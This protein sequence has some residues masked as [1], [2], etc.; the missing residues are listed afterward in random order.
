MAIYARQFSRG[1]LAQLLEFISSV[2]VARIE[3]PIYLM[4]S[5]V[6][7]R[8]PGS[9]PKD[10]LRLWFDASGMVGYVWFE[11]ATGMEFDVRD[12]L[13]YGHPVAAEM[14]A[15]AE[16]RRR[17]FDPAY[18]RFVDLTSMTQWADEI[19]RPRVSRIR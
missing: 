3:A 9:G 13:G 2:A 19:N 17:E 15:W 11:P 1:D 7:W 8:L 10:N 16:T 14:L 5:D 18:P 6:A 4:T 12:D